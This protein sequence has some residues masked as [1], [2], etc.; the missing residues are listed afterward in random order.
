MTACN[1]TPSVTVSSPSLL[2]YKT[3]C[4]KCGQTVTFLSAPATGDGESVAP[5]TE[6]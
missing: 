4:S 5:E 2:A 3:A 1:H 6:R